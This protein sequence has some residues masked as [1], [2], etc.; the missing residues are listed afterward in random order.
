MPAT[1][2][3]PNEAARQAVEA[4]LSNMEESSEHLRDCA[5]AMK[6]V[7]QTQEQLAAGVTASVNTLLRASAEQARQLAELTRAMGALQE[8]MGYLTKVVGEAQGIPIAP[9]QPQSLVDQGMQAGISFLQQ[10]LQNQI[11]TNPHFPY[12]QPPY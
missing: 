1:K 6:R 7:A 2:S 3:K 5:A 8:Q 4:L 11:N 9:R 10:Q 12:N